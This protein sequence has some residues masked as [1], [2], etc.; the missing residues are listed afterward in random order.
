MFESLTKRLNGIQAALR[1]KGKLKQQDV[2]EVLLEI[3]EALVDADVHFSVAEGFVEQVSQA[4]VGA[5]IQSALNPEQQIIKILNEELT[6]L[7]GGSVVDFQLSGKPPVSI[8]MA[9]LQGTGKTTTS[10]KLA[11]WLKKN[12]RRPI[13]VGTDLQRPAALEQLQVLAA[14]QDIPVVCEGK[15]PKAVAQSGLKTAKATGRDVLICDTAG[16]TGV[17]V[18]L[19]DELTQIEKVLTAGNKSV[20]HTLL[21]VDSMSGQDSLQVSRDFSNAISISGIIL[22]KLDGDARGGAA[23]SARHLINQPIYFASTGEQLE[24]FDVFHPD[25][26]AGRI[27]GMGDVLTLIEKTQATYEAEQIELEEEKF[28]KMLAGKVTL[29]DFLEQM[30]LVQKMGVGSVIG[31]LPSDALPVGS[32]EVDIDAAEK[33]FTKMEAMIS[34]MTKQERLNPEIIDDSRR[35][36][37]AAGSGATPTEVSALVREFMGMR[38][39]MKKM[40]GLQKLKSKMGL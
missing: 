27:L 15:T 20:G 4:A 6:E 22:T 10:V 38:K 28:E 30:R 25:R 36:R 26:L 17:D 16:R 37:I 7:L 33:K 21:V 24:D 11:S 31:Q 5:E 14:S 1:K 18:E 40:G 3:R 13:L 35:K 29:D 23:L 8:L 32:G 19:M 34:S 12:G 9:G 39:E 2:D